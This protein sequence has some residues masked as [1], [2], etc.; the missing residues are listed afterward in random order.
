M[1]EELDG[2]ELEDELEELLL[3]L[4]LLLEEELLELELLLLEELEELEL[5]EELLLELLEELDELLLELE[6]EV[7][8]LVD[9]E[10]LVVV[11]LDWLS[12]ALTDSSVESLTSVVEGVSVV[13]GLL[14]I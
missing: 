12:E 8:V 14:L 10:A 2:F 7:D 6:L 3:E 4:E 11:S 13:V 9:V 5:L 1:L